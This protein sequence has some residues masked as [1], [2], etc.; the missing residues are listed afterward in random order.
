MRLLTLPVIH[1]DTFTQTAHGPDFHSNI[2]PKSW[3][4]V[5]LGSLSEAGR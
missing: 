4:N 5:R 1:T 3:S 2:Q